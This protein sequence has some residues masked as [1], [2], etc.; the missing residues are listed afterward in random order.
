M[1]NTPSSTQEKR[2]QE[3][4][5]IA[6]SSLPEALE[7]TS[8]E[9]LPAA[10]HRNLDV[11]DTNTNAF[12]TAV[13]PITFYKR[14]WFML[15]I[16]SLLNCINAVIWLTFAP[17]ATQ[18]TVRFNVS[19][20][21][22]NWLSGVFML[23]YVPMGFM[24]T[25]ALDAGSLRLGCGIG[26]I[27]NAVGAIARMGSSFY[28]L[29]Q[30]HAA[31][32]WVM[33]GQVLCACAQ[34]F[35]LGATTK[36][37]CAWFND[38]QRALANT[39]G[40]I[41]NPLGIAVSSIVSPILVPLNSSRNQLK[42]RIDLLMYIYG[43]LAVFS[44]ALVFWLRSNPPTSASIGKQNLLPEGNKEF[45]RGVWVLCRNSGYMML[46]G[47][48]G[49]GLGMFNAVTTLLEQILT[50]Y[51]YT[52]DESGYGAAALIVCGLMGAFINGV[53]LDKYKKY[54]EALRFS[55][56]GATLSLVWFSIVHSIPD[57]LIQIIISLALLGMFAFAILP[58]TLEL[59]AECTYP[60]NEGT[61]SGFL[62]MSG[63][64]VGLIFIALSDGP[65]KH[66][67]N[68]SWSV[69]FLTG[70]GGIACI[71]TFF[72]RGDY[73]RSKNENDAKGLLTVLQ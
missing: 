19:S 39:I 56:V 21:A 46:I 34:P 8:K 1:K 57:Q 31:F 65:L 7:P 14:R 2:Q 71:F 60:V 5:S 15:F 45:V 42:T 9:I 40:S 24:A 11:S 51:G 53:I 23:A 17:I 62:Y 52:P 44:S 35:V 18:S 69:Y 32:G 70:M 20:S 4:A 41:A 61:S 22:I 13:Q 66:A 6:L 37:A 28:S 59:A 73:V 33:A 47:A 55:F 30:G 16:L 54:I 12:Y 38:D 50:P 48:F 64:L 29:E 49:I 58:T 67:G 27:L 68:L 36:L 43:G 63:N 25:W 10:I 72:W 3:Q 26:A